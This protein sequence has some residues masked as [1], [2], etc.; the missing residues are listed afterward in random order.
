[1]PRKSA[2]AGTYGKVT[3]AQRHDKR[4]N[5]Y[6][7]LFWR[8]SVTICGI[9]SYGGAYGLTIILCDTVKKNFKQTLHGREFEGTAAIKFLRNY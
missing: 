8:N 1:L 4:N 2:S 6:Q 9:D 7:N 5:Y 3:S